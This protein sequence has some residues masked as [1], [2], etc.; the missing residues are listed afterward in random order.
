[1]RKIMCGIVPYNRRPFII[2]M[3][4]K[5]NCEPEHFPAFQVEPDTQDIVEIQMP[6]EFNLS[7]G[8]CLI[9]FSCNS[10]VA[11]DNRPLPQL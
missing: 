5:L 6:L 2:K 1:M 8:L 7:H 9:A 3:A 10:K 4:L 11:Y